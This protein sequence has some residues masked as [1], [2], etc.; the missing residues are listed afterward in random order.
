MPTHEQ[1]IEIQVIASTEHEVDQ[2]FSQENLTMC[3]VIE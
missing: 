2:A 3:R 1:K